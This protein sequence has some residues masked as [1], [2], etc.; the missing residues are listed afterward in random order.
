V[1]G[2]FFRISN[3]KDHVAIFPPL[4]NKCGKRVTA[5][6]NAQRHGCRLATNAGFFNVK[7]GDCLGNL[8]SDGHIIQTADARVANFGVRGNKFVVGYV[9]PGTVNSSN[10][11]FSHLVAGVGWLVRN[12]EIYLEEAMKQEH[13]SD[14]FRTL[15][16]PRIAIG[17]DA[18][19]HLMILEVNGYEPAHL[20]FTLDQMAST[21]K[22][23]GAINMINLDGMRSFRIYFTLSILPFPMARVRMMN[24]NLRTPMN[25]LPGRYIMILENL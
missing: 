13:I 25:A 17:H 23:M 16:A 11:P 20:G 8:V 4:E 9:D 10:P 6:S 15:L 24:Q 14:A 7:N 21:A 2:N 22:A 12:G 18:K 5:S 1:T 19:G 3:P